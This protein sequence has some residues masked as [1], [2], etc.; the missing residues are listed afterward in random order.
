MI[1]KTIV[2]LAIIAI[3]FI[4]LF[5]SIKNLIGSLLNGEYFLTFLCFLGV[6]FLVGIVLMAADI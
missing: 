4:L 3:Y 6:A 1:G 2:C 5:G